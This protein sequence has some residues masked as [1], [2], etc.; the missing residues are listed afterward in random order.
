MVPSF[1]VTPVAVGVLVVV[2]AGQVAAQLPTQVL[3]PECAASLS[4]TYRVIPEPSTTIVPR[5]V[6]AVDISPDAGPGI[7]AE[8]LVEELRELGIAP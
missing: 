6:E 3:V 2:T 8:G 5:E 4:K 1:P 7:A